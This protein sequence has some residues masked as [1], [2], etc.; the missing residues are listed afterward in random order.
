MSF[1]HALLSLCAGF[2]AI[3]DPND[4]A[5]PI[6]WSSPN[7]T[8]MIG[9]D[10]SDD[11]A[12]DSDLV[13]IRSAI[14]AWSAP[15]CT[16]LR[17]IDGGELAN[18]VD[19][20]DGV[21]AIFFRE[22]NWPGSLSGA[23]AVTVHHENSGSPETWHDADILLN[24]QD[25]QWSTTGE[26]QRFDIQSVVTHELGHLIGPKHVAHP[27]PTMYFV[28]PRGNLQRRS[29]HPSDV[30]AV[31]WLYPASGMRGCTDSDGCPMMISTGGATV[32]LACSNGQCVPGAVGYGGEC[33]Q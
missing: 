31:C 25:L 26:T 2:S 33:F 13:A 9:A 20:D 18:P 10:G 21:N 11:V 22:S 32:R 28:A 15:S 24:G 16:N 6:V 30:A 4:P 12:G 8:L 1:A 14:A 3:G 7:V 19:A 5:T 23:A 29:L 17:L 27:Q